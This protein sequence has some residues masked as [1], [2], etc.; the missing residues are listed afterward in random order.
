MEGPAD[1]DAVVVGDDPPA[2][3]VALAEVGVVAHGRVR[4]GAVVYAEDFHHCS[5]G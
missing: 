4:H 2:A 5:N 1:A 3:E